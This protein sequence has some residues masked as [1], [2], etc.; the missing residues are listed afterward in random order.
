MSCPPTVN[1]YLMRPCKVPRS[2]NVYIHVN[3][4]LAIYTSVDGEGQG[5]STMKHPSWGGDKL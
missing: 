2:W 5:L 3:K 4:N 1:E